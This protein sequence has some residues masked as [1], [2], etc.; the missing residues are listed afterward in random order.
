MNEIINI[1]DIRNIIVRFPSCAAEYESFR[2]YLEAEMNESDP[3]Y[4]TLDDK[5][6]DLRGPDFIKYRE[7]YRKETYTWIGDSTRD[8]HKMNIELSYCDFSRYNRFDPK[9][10]KWKRYYLNRKMTNVPRLYY[11]YLQQGEHYYL[12]T[13]LLVKCGCTSYEDIRTIDGQEHST[14]Y[15][16]CKALGLLKDDEEY[17]RCMREAVETHTPGQLISM[18]VIFRDWNIFVCA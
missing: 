14:F 3:L 8:P 16:A 13:L 9:E 5:K 1:C 4:N 15:D 12:R 17:F 2:G 18:F 10:K 6:T 7:M 11:A